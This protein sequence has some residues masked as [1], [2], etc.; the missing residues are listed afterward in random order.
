MAHRSEDDRPVQDVAE[1]GN[2]PNVDITNHSDG[3]EET[4]ETTEEAEED[5]MGSGVPEA[6]A[7]NRGNED[8]DE[9]HEDEAPSSPGSREVPGSGQRRRGRIIED[10]DPE[11]DSN[12][13]EQSVTRH[14]KKHRS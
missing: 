5:I 9:E 14:G 4:Q 7:D 3:E 8:N 1:E 13:E 10:S 2:D 11:D 6:E 12:G